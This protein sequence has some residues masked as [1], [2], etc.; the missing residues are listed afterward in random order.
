[1]QSNIF[2]LLFILGFFTGCSSRNDFELSQDKK[3][4]NRIKKVLDKDNFT[5]LKKNDSLEKLINTI[6]QDSLRK[7]MIFMVSYQFYKDNDSLL[8]RKWHLK[9]KKLSLELKDSLKLAESYWDLASFFY[10]RE[11][12]DSSYYNYNKAY[13]LYQQISEPVYAGRML[14]NMAIIEKNIHDFTRSEI[15]STKALRLLKNSDHVKSMYIIYNNLGILYNQ[16][17]EYEKAL[18]HHSKALDYI[19]GHKDY[20]SQYKAV[21]LNNVGVVYQ[22]QEEHQRAI[23]YFQKAFLVDSIFEKQP[24][25][26]AMLLDNAAYSRLKLKDTSHV[27]NDMN[28][29]LEIRDSINHAA[30]I[31]INKIHLSE[32]FAFKKDTSKAVELLKEAN[33]FAFQKNFPQEQLESLLRLSKLNEESSSN[34]LEKYIIL[35][36]SLQQEE[37][38]IRNKFA[39]IKF[40][41]D[42]VIEE[43]KMLYEQRK[44]IIG[45]SL[46]FAL[47]GFSGFVIKSQRNKNQKLLLK[48]EQQEANEKILRLL[49]SRQTLTEEGREKERKR[50]SEELHD[51]I[52]AKLFGTRMS[53]DSLNSKVDNDSIEKRKKYLSDLKEI[54]QELRDLSH[55][56]N[57]SLD[58]FQNNYIDLLEEIL[59]QHSSSAEFD[60]H[61]NVDKTI[62]WEK[63]SGSIK[64]HI[65]RI[66]QEAI[67]NIHVHSKAKKVQITLKE[68]EDTLTLCIKDN[69]VGIETY[70]NLKEGL[71]F[72]NMSSRAK[73]MKGKFSYSSEKGEGMIIL[74][75]IPLLQNL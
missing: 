34:Y 24:R 65:Y 31:I 57:S 49:L 27:L 4:E 75:E 64:L 15:T 40:E 58:T 35:K 43:N 67:K 28:R 70:K 47:L 13:N 1:M 21:S 56:F 10:N 9:S 29:S 52:L 68:K 46:G 50:L 14:T 12:L 62:N 19:D 48:Q 42:H 51:G 20:L 11:I 39:K 33:Q 16:L 72:K 60:Y 25:I 18:E 2:F 44:I 41:T 30:G 22:N 3:F 54:S 66:V 63:I 73:S 17:K 74:I 37:R 6:E 55:Q 36:D 53:L 61:L 7:R 8:F 71:G 32:F 69:G 45:L 26:F 5:S 23:R 38:T 59:K